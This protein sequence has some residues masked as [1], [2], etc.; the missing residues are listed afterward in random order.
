[1]ITIVELVVFAAGFLLGL[2]GAGCLRAAGGG[3]R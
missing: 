1:M 2:I 3:Q